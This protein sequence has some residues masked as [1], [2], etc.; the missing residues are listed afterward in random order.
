MSEQTFA[1]GKDEKIVSKNLLS[2]SLILFFIKSSFEIT[3]KRLVGQVPNL[4]WIFPIGKNTVTYPLKNIAGVRLDNKFSLK[5][6]IIG[7]I[8]IFIGL[9]NFS[10]LFIVFII[11][12]FVLISTFEIFFVV[13]NTAGATMSYAVSPL[14]KAQAQQLINELNQIIADNV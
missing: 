11:G 1:L 8:L 10:S 5:R 4:L 14:E 7:L 12:I 9:S 6:F 3:N 2:F 13:Q